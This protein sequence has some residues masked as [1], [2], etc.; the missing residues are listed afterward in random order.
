MRSAINRNTETGNAPKRFVSE[1]VISNVTSRGVRTLQKDRLLGRGPFPYYKIN[2]QV[3]Y[4]LDEV[5]AI[6]ES[7][8]VVGGDA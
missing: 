2:R 6:I 7:S 4:N 8:R 3:A 5:L 1:R